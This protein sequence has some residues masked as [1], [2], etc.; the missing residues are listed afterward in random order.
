MLKAS[1]HARH[2]DMWRA[3]L[4]ELVERILDLQ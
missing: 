1:A 3:E 2:R 4:R